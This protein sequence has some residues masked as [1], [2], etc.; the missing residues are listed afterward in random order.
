MRCVACRVSCRARWEEEKNAVDGADDRTKRRRKLLNDAREMEEA[1]A[2]EDLAIR[3]KGGRRN[4]KAEMARDADRAAKRDALRETMAKLEEEEEEADRLRT[5]I[6]ASLKGQ[7]GAL[8]W[9]TVPTLHR[10]NV[11][12]RLPVFMLLRLAPTTAIATRDAVSTDLHQL[13]VVP[14]TLQRA[15]EMR[16]EDRIRGHR[17]VQRE[18]QAFLKTVADNARR[19]E[20]EELDLGRNEELIQHRTDTFQSWVVLEKLG[21][22]AIKAAL[23]VE[24]A[25]AF[26]RNVGDVARIANEQCKPTVLVHQVKDL[27]PYEPF[28]VRIVSEASWAGAPGGG[29]SPGVPPSFSTIYIRATSALEPTPAALPT[30][31]AL[32]LLLL[33][34]SIISYSVALVVLGRGCLLTLGFLDVDLGVCLV[35]CTVGRSLRGIVVC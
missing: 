4:V 7:K 22:R 28:D 17:E 8:K 30:D 6:D 13:D 9:L 14:V 32:L 26:L 24:E 16:D 10:D 5:F 18:A 21:N 25:E 19:K 3:K 12:R 20:R 35:V 2:A 11:L 34:L 33:L 29:W 31:G 15:R 1:F 23:V 27:V